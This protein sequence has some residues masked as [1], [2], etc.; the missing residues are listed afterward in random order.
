MI[1]YYFFFQTTTNFGLSFI[2]GF[3]RKGDVRKARGERMEWEEKSIILRNQICAHLQW[4]ISSLGKDKY[5]FFSFLKLKIFLF[6]EF[7]KISISSFYSFLELCIKHTT[8]ELNI[9]LKHYNTIL[10]TKKNVFYL[11]IIF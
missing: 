1:S 6:S 3:S 7:N 2:N 5:S 11:R 9:L 4:R 8:K 10:K